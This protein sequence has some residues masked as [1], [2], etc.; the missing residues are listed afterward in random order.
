MRNLIY[1]ILL[2]C[3]LSMVIGCR[4]HYVPVETAKTEYKD[5]LERDSIY[6]KELVKVYQKGDTVF[7]D[8]IVYKYRDRQVKDTVNVTDTIRVPY[9]ITEIKE[10]NILKNW[11]ILLM[12][13]GG[14]LL[15]Y[16]GFRI[17]RWIK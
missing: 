8:S 16:V 7:R 11:Q 2:L 13:L 1:I 14:V 9:P 17:I 15:G 3:I 6:F 4:T 10:V 5:R 12:C